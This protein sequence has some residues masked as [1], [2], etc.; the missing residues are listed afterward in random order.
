MFIVIANMKN[1]N[2]EEL[3]EIAIKNATDFFSLNL[4]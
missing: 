4:N 3:A 2:V 1:I